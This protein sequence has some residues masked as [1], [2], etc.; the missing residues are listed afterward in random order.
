MPPIQAKLN[1]LTKEKEQA[2]AD[3]EETVLGL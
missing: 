2:E 1:E 3:L